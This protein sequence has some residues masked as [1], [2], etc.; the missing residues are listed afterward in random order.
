MCAEQGACVRRRSWAGYTIN[1]FE[2]EF[3]TGTSIKTWHERC[4]N[5]PVKEFGEAI[6]FWTRNTKIY[7]YIVRNHQAADPNASQIPS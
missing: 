5:L 4:L 3:P 7:R 2:F 1:M 6:I